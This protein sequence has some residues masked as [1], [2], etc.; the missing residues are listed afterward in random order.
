MTEETYQEVVDKIK[1]EKDE[2]DETP[3]GLERSETEQKKV[4]ITKQQMS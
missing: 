2:K 1:E 4:M 3:P